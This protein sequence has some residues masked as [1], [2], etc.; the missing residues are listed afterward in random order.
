MSRDVPQNLKPEDPDSVAGAEAWLDGL[1]GRGGIGPE[2]DEGRLIRE[3]VLGLTP[4]EMPPWS[5]IERRAAQ[6]EPDS[7]VAV[8]A[9]PEQRSAANQPFWRVAYGLAAALVLGV[10]VTWVV[11]RPEPEATMRGG[12]QGT[13]SWATW[14]VVQPDAAAK[15]LALELQ[16]LGAQ[17]DQTRLGAEQQLRVQARPEVQAAV[18]QRLA[19]LELALD[20][21][22][23]M[24]LRV[25]A[26]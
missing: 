12:V 25:T 8:V 6:V 15:Q 5:E 7:Q 23:R 2:Y 9:E 14:V 17:V 11:H 19:A 20:A 13:S 4:I 16:A 1:A 3:S 22:G 10:A 18:N 24:N 26:P 21:Q